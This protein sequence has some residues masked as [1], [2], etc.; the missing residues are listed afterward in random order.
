MAGILD[1]KVAIVTGAG[2]KSFTVG[3]DLKSFVS[4]APDLGEIV[5]SQKDQ[6]LNRGLEV[7]K[8]VIAAVNGHCLG[9]G[10]TL[11]SW[12]DFVIASDRATFERALGDRFEIE[13]TERLGTRTL[14]E[15][16]P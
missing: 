5:L 13:R 3:A 12:C 8:P 14:F 4:Q 16:R 1:G 7:W 11:V 2:E 15:A 9:Y 10:L 6:L